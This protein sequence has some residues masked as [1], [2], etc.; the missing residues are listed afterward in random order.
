MV[1]TVWTLA[2]IGLLLFWGCADRRAEREKSAERMYYV[3]FRDL[4]EELERLPQAIE[5][6]G[7]IAGKYPDTESG[8]RAKVRRAQLAEAQAMLARAD[9]LSGNNWES[10]YLRIHAAAP[11]YPP[12]LRKLGTYYYNNTYLGARAGAMT[13]HPLIVENMFRLWT[14]QDS[15]WSG[16]EFRPTP[17]DRAWRDN[18]CRQATHI[19]RMLEHV[20]R[21]REALQVINRGL[22]YGVGEDVLA[23]ARVFASFYTFRQ[24]RYRE[25]IDLAKE[26]LSYEFLEK[27]DRARAF[28]VIGLC[29][30]TIYQQSNDTADL[31]AAIH[32]L[33]EALG[34][35]PNMEEVRDMLKTLRKYRQT[36]P[37]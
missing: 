25:S 10:Y 16:Y 27:N 29:Y 37:S 5:R 26:A 4:E 1:R 34:I 6:Y 35:D 28:H 23:H 13:Q 14:V 32:A 24:A 19:A 20:R 31:D 8:K 36:L 11:G 30:Q 33:N 7:E 18:L 17:A 22:E 9:S 2:G 12:V 21:Y 3:A 15:L